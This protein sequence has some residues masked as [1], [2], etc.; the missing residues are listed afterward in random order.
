MIVA[1]KKIDLVARAGDKEK[2]LKQLRKLGVV[3]LEPVDKGRLAVPAELAGKLADFTRVKTLLESVPA[4]PDGDAGNLSA[5][6]VKEQVLADIAQ[7][8][9]L[10]E[11]I[12]RLNKEYSDVQ[13]WGD[14]NSRDIHAISDR[15]FTKFLLIPEQDMDTYLDYMIWPAGKKDGKNCV[16]LVARDAEIEFLP[17]VEEIEIPQ[18]DGRQIQELIKANKDKIANLHEEL[19][20][21]GASR[22]L[23]EQAIKELEA[24]SEFAFALQGGLETEDLFGVSGWVPAERQEECEEFGRTSE[25]DMALK[26]FEAGE[27]EDPPS[28]VK[29]PG[30]VEPISSIF[31]ILGTVPGYKEFDISAPFIIFLSLFAA[32]LIGD[33]GYGLVL[34]LPTAVFYKK[35]AKAISP[36][37]AMM[38]IIIGACVTIY[39]FLTG[40]FFGLQSKDP[41]LNM[42]QEQV[43][44]L[45]F[46]IGAVHLVVARLWKAARKFP[47]LSFLSEVGWASVVAG[48]MFVVFM[49]VLGEAGMPPFVPYLIGGGIALV[50]LFTTPSWNPLTP[51][52]HLMDT[53]L[54]TLSCFSDVISYVR[55]MAVGMASI[56]LAQSFNDLAMNLGP[57]WVGIPVLVLGHLLNIGLAG[58]ALFAHGVR[59]NMLEFCNHLGMEWTGREYEPFCEKN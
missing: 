11:E 43:M 10:E 50:L 57:I 59:L 5:E 6:Q 25:T 58:I 46:I 34:L 15:L 42:S 41:V 31:A 4:K 39:G 13:A 52:K 7:M 55:L 27:D 2:I 26:V 9:E 35:V 21:F 16:F 23:V 33:A 29:N 8:E 37:G 28:L 19:G 38:T 3:H 48:I 45:C 17:G 20:R 47:H 54:S 14:F 12:S 36:Q 51:L 49:L 18:R 32:M 56:V 1:M 44:K 40:V 30:W 24:E 53:V 22:P